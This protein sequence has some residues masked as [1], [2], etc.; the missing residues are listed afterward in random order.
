MLRSPY[1][2]PRNFLTKNGGSIKTLQRSG[3]VKSVDSLDCCKALKE[4][5]LLRGRPIYLHGESRRRRDL[6]TGIGIGSPER[7]RRRPEC[8]RDHQE[9]WTPQS[10]RTCLDSQTTQVTDTSDISHCLVFLM[11]SLST[12]SA[13]IPTFRRD[14][15]KRLRIPLRELADLGSRAACE[16]SNPPLR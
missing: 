13:L 4:E 8:Y 16:S 2:L 10:G 15:A 7:I 12:L 1:F 9:D 11:P 6:P 3:S 14:G 5:R